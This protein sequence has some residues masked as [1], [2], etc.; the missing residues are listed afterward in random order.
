MYVIDSSAF[1]NSTLF[2]LTCYLPYSKCV[3]FL[4]QRAFLACAYFNNKLRETSIT[5]RSSSDRPFR[6]DTRLAGR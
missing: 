3:T 5:R 2:S 1:V 4:K 6:L